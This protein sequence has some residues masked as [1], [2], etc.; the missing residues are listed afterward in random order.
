MRPRDDISVPLTVTETDMH[1]WLTGM[2]AD[3]AMQQGADPTD[4][5]C[6]PVP[7][8]QRLGRNV[9]HLRAI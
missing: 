1:A 4:A 3:S 9:Q 6:P 8:G 2:Q 5:T 7:A